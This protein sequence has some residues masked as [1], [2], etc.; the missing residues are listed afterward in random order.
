MWICSHSYHLYIN[1]DLN[2]MSRILDPGLKAGVS[3]SIIFSAAGL[4]SWS[5]C[6]TQTAAPP[7]PSAGR[8]KI[9]YQTSCIA[10]HN[11]DPR[12]PGTLGPEVFGSSKDLLEARIMRAEYPSGYKPKRTTHTMVALPY[13]KNDLESIYLFLQS[14]N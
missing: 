3:L 14:G 11:P 13:L 4:L 12:K 5:G 8:G 1:G 9:V 10:C 7:P 6:N 2:E